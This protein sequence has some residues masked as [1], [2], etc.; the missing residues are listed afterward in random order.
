MEE[1]LKKEIEQWNQSLE[2][3]LKNFLARHDG[4]I[5]KEHVEIFME[6]IMYVDATNVIVLSRRG[7]SPTELKQYLDE[8]SALSKKYGFEEDLETQ[9]YEGLKEILEWFKDA[10]NQGAL[11]ARVGTGGGNA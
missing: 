4:R 5:T 2:E 11:D 10:Y 1:K 8:L 7:L 9:M 3:K 6:A